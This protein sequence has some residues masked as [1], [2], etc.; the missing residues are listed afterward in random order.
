M[1][2][3]R[4]KLVNVRLILKF[5]DINCSLQ[6]ASAILEIRT[7][8]EVFTSRGNKVRAAQSKVEETEHIILR[9]VNKLHLLY[10][11][12]YEE[13]KPYSGNLK[14][15]RNAAVIGEYKRRGLTK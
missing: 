13:P 4:L 1:I 8:A 14:P 3:K 2:Y 6:N 12:P 10:L 5:L 15:E 7:C 11:N 9:P